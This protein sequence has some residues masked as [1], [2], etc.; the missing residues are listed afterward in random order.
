MAAE[1]WVLELC[2]EET[3]EFL[4]CGLAGGLAVTVV[5]MSNET[6]IMFRYV[7]DR[8]ESSDTEITRRYKFRDR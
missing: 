3:P 8:F 2:V 4:S 5:G 7:D 1:A 6:R